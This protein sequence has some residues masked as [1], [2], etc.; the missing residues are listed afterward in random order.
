MIFEVEK[1]L[2]Q[3]HFVDLV[4]SANDWNQGSRQ[5]EGQGSGHEVRNWQS[6]W[7]SLFKDKTSIWLTDESQGGCGNHTGQL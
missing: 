6:C 5:G 1:H 7:R 4:L 3:V 2:A